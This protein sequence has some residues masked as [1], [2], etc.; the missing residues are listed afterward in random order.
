MADGTPIKTAR[1]VNAE[2]PACAIQMIHGFGEHIGR[3]DEMGKALARRGF[4]FVVYDQR[5]H[6]ARDHLTEKERKRD[7]GVAG[8]YDCF[9]DDMDEVYKAMRKW[10][11]GIDVILMGHSMGGNI[12]VNYLLRRSQEK[13]KM[14]ILETPWLRLCNP[15]PGYVLALA[16]RLGKISPGFAITDKLNIDAITRDADKLRE[17]KHDYTVCKIY[18]TRLSLRL[19]AQITD[20]GEYAITGARNLD[21]PILLL[22]ANDDKIVSPAAI[23]DFKS[24]SGANVEIMEYEQGYHALH[25]DLIREAVMEDAVR[26]IERHLPTCRTS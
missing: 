11:P 16:R 20:A 5:G 22:C 13:Y 8:D 10:Y 6:G 23:R 18:H 15:K 26:F 7:N 21:L 24:R 1:Y 19:Y 17:L 14:A 4:A 25:N 12:A 9:L 3:Y 2:K